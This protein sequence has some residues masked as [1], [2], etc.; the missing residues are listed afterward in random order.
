M[1]A[2]TLPA[3]LNGATDL[4]ARRSR[5]GTAPQLR[6]TSLPRTAMPR[7]L[8]LPPIDGLDDTREENN[9]RRGDAGE[10]QPDAFGAV[11]QPQGDQGGV[12]G[13]VRD[14]DRGTGPAPT[15]LDRVRLTERDIAVIRHLVLLRLLRYDQLH[16]LAFAAVDRSIAR[17]RIRL[18][19]RS[20]WLATWEVPSPQGGHARYAHPT[21]AA[22]RAL[23]PT[24]APNAA[25]APLVS[26]MVPRQRRPLELG[27][28]T[29][30]WLPHQRE[31]N[32]LVTSIATSP[33][34]RI[35]WASSWDCPFPSRV[36]MFEFPQP[37]YVLVE[38][39][40]SAPRLV[41]GEHDR[42]SEPLDRFTARKLALYSALAA[43][44]DVCE[45]QF[46]I[47]SFRVHITVS[48]PLRRAP[49]A[50]LRALLEA[51][52]SAERPDI[53]RFAL[54]GWLYACPAAPIWIGVDHPPA[55]DSVARFEH[56]GVL[57]P[58]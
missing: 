29:P 35:L 56:A 37:D 13:R 27:T 16:R 4:R 53:F 43:F 18:L 8:A 7:T 39:V 5:L 11:N 47:S 12:R 46:G 10:P 20:G 23:L 30:K 51:A 22:I 32:H 44:P 57:G 31:V 42:G 19:V 49:M 55:H 50:R 38:E 17:R 52:R 58:G 36:G 9:Q 45:Q 25:W 3:S 6:T 41:F 26:R 1:C 34:R 28:S 48:D 33:E 2:G 54:G 40:D 24:L 21:A 14:I 15:D